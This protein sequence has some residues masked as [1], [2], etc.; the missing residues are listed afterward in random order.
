MSNH[1][2]IPAAAPGAL[3]DLEPADAVTMHP[4]YRK[5]L[6][7]MQ[8]NVLNCFAEFYENSA[9]AE[10]TTFQI[11]AD[12]ESSRVRLVDDGKGLPF[13]DFKDMLSLGKPKV[14]ELGGRGQGL[15]SSCARL[16][17]GLPNASVFLFAKTGS[18]DMTCC[19]YYHPVRCNTT[20]A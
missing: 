6:A 8:P 19:A 12:A 3:A 16:I 5:T 13:S 2:N 1:D 9:N 10:A 18:M 17:D 11:D 4:A 14:S 15:R 7:E 20:L